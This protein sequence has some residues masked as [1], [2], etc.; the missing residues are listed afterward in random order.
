MLTLYE[1]P[2]SGNCHKVRLLLS[3]L[4]LKY[5]SIVLQREN[6]EQKSPD[7]LL[8]NPYGQ[9]PVLQDGELVIRDSQAILVY[10]A[11][12]YGDANWLPDDAAELAQ[13]MGWLST[14]ANEV[15][16]GPNALRLLHKFGRVINESEAQQITHSLLALMQMRLSQHDWLALEHISIADIAMYPYIALAGEGGVQVDEYSSVTDWLSRIQALS[17]YVGMPGMWSVTSS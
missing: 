10:L 14:A 12:R 8:K 5:Q 1:F 6:Q 9:V 4:G 16:H 11:K 7:F 15:T 13:V 2:V 3:L 17:G